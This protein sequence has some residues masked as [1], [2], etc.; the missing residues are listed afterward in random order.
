M[1]LISSWQNSATLISLPNRSVFI[2]Y[3][4]LK[5]FSHYDCTDPRNPAFYIPDFFLRNKH[6][7]VQHEKW[8]KFSIK[9]LCGLLGHCP[10]EDVVSWNIRHKELFSET[11]QKLQALF[12]EN[13][14]EKAVPYIFAYASETMTLPRLKASLKRALSVIETYPVFLYGHWNNEEGFLGVT[15]EIL[16]EHDQTNPKVLKTMALAGTGKGSKNRHE[17]ENNEKDLEEHRVVIEGIKQTLQHLGH[18]SISKTEVLSLPALKHLLTPMNVLLRHPFDFMST[19]LCMHPTPALGAFPRQE[20]ALWLEDYQMQLDRQNYGAPF[21]FKIDSLGLSAC[22]AAIRQVQWN[23]LGMRIGAGCGI[24]EKSLPEKEWEEIRL[25]IS[26]I[27]KAL[28]L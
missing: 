27:R 20:G 2:G 26:A 11:F 1:E 23:A 6:P 13:K 28:A 9:E 14:L 15:P 3:G 16:F 24:I 4:P 10:N 5:M 18:V 25:K 12:K 22:L 21:G 19:V 17:F 7:W 8:C